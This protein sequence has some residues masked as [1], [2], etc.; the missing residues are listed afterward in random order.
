MRGRTGEEGGGE[1]K[2]EGKGLLNEGVIGIEERYCSR[3][4]RSWPG[5]HL[6]EWWRQGARG[7]SRQVSGFLESLLPFICGLIQDRS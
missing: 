2:G 3:T 6:L 7:A 1:G 4:I 5:I